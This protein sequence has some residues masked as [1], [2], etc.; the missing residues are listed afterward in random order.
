M[1]MDAHKTCFYSAY[2]LEYLHIICLYV[3][4]SNPLSLF[5][6]TLTMNNTDCM[7]TV[8]VHIIVITPRIIP[9]RPSSLSCVLSPPFFF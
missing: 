9:S 1:N 3:I 7:S 5:G 8:F 4:E 6:T 2:T